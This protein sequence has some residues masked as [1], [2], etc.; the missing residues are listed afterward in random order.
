[1]N[2]KVAE[3]IQEKRRICDDMDFV[4]HI[5]RDTGIEDILGLCG[6]Q[7]YSLLFSFFFRPPCLLLIFDGGGDVMCVSKKKK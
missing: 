7:R 2:A 4:D 3:A 1:M 6:V 5:L